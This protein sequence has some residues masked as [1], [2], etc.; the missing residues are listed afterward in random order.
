[1]VWPQRGPGGFT[2]CGRSRVRGVVSRHD[3]SSCATLSW[4]LR[5]GATLVIAFL[6]VTVFGRPASAETLEQA[7]ADAYLI[8]P[9][10]NAERARGSEPSTS[11]WLA[12]PGLRPFI[13]GTA[14]VGVRH[15]KTVTKREPPI[16]ILTTPPIQLPGGGGVSEE[17]TNPRGYAVTLSSLLRDFRT[18]MPLGRRRRRCRW[19]GRRWQR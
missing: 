7:L 2:N 13:F 6:V 14:D 10:L 5:G 15:R 1:M 19:P 3:M 8:N 9:V 11:R 18:S 4:R 17:T 12:S 16:T